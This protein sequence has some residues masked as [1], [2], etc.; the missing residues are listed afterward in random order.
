MKTLSNIV[1]I[2]SAM[3]LLTLAAGIV[4]TSAD[5]SERS[6]EHTTS[7]QGQIHLSDAVKVGNVLLKPGMY[8]VQHVV[9]ANDHAVEFKKV[10]M[11][12]G[13]RH[14]N[15]QVAKEAVARVTCSFQP[16]TKNSRNTKMTLRTNGAGEKELVE[17]QIAGEPF[18]HLF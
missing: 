11:V 8:Q 17:L 4:N 3:A 5:N 6:P 13:Y 7:S 14:G 10:E 12:A 9:T 1:R 15:L 16:A 18:R 2:S